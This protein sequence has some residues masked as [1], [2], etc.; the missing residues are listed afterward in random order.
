VDWWIEGKQPKAKGN[1]R[2]TSLRG[3]WL[4]RVGSEEPLSIGVAMTH[5]RPGTS[6]LQPSNEG[7]KRKEGKKR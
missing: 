4:E 1:P 3:L 2:D 7:A 6:Q 5:S